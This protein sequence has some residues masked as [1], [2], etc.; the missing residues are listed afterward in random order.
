[1]TTLHPEHG[2]QS[3]KGTHQYGA[4]ATRLWQNFVPMG[5][6]NYTPMGGFVNRLSHDDAR[7]GLELGRKRM[8]RREQREIGRLFDPVVAPDAGP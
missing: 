6:G 4:A 1:M 8:R 2:D 7:S 3:R 5:S